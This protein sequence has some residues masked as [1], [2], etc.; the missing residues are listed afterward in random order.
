MAEVYVPLKVEM[1]DIPRAMSPAE[2]RRFLNIA[3]SKEH[4]IIVHR[5]AVLALRTCMSTLELR[6]LKRRDINLDQGIVVVQARGAKNP[7]RIRTIPLHEEARSAAKWLLER[8]A[9]IG[10]TG[11]ENFVF[12]FRVVRNDFDPKRPMGEGGLRYQWE[13]VR[14][15]AD[16]PWLRPYDLRHTAITRFAEA[17]TSI[18]I[19]MEFAGHVSQRMTAHYTHISQQAKVMAANKAGAAVV[20]ENNLNSWATTS[21][22]SANNKS[23]SGGIN[24]GAL[25]S[26]L[27]AAGM[28]SD[29]ILQIIQASSS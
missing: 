20:A 18:S 1:L 21:N 22:P 15:A 11:T 26:N 16:L 10:S 4:W 13:E 24:I 17:G 29:S 12:P 27:R 9:S 5:Y 19:I 3:E 14:K 6:H 7:Y 23:G 28:D 8:A 25:I 2:Q